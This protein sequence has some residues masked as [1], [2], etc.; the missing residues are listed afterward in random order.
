MIVSRD[1]AA[2][3]GDVD[4]PDPPPPRIGR[5]PLEDPPLFP[6]WPVDLPERH[7]GT[8]RPKS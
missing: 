1:F 2:I 6:R 7:A 3:V 5:D 8:E 4:R